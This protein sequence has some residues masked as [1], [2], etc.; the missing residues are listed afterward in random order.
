[1]KKQYACRAHLEHPQTAHKAT[2][3]DTLRAQQSSW[4]TNT[5]TSSESEAD[6]PNKAQVMPCTKKI[7]E[8]TEI[9][10]S[11]LLPSNGSNVKKREKTFQLFKSLGYFWG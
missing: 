4:Q 1:M 6:I 8:Y 10:K 11:K 7:T 2:G 3:T 5:L 9:I